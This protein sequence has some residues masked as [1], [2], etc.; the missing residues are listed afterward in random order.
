MEAARRR[1]P[2][3]HVTCFASR[4]SLSAL[5]LLAA[6]T[7]GVSTPV[8]V[9]PAAP[10]SSGAD[11]AQPAASAPIASTD[12]LGTWVEYWAVA[13]G[14]DTER[15][16]FT[17]ATHFEWDA[18]NAAQQTNNPGAIRKVGTFRVE[19]EGPTWMLVLEVQRE[20]FPACAAPCTSGAREVDHTTPLVERYELG[21]CP[22]NPE[23]QSV[24][25]S[26][27]CRAF[28]GKAFW[29]K[30]NGVRAT[31]EAPTAPLERR[32]G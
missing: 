11:V 32:T 31:R 15:Y 10:R 8:A 27:T 12:L 22:S 26:Y 7:D 29:R 5:A 17:D 2:G 16:A 6:C 18:M 25:A 4:I 9:E 28:G 14:A 1:A 21:D 13:G 20:S 19:R 3:A 24:D 23:A 30:S